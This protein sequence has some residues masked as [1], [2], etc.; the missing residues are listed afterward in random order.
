MARN[1]IYDDSYEDPEDKNERQVRERRFF[2][3]S[4]AA[5]TVADQIERIYIN[6][7]SFKSALASIDRIFQL[8]SRTTV[9]QGMMLIGEPGTGKSCVMKLFQAYAPRDALFSPSASTIL[10]RLQ[11]KP[12]VGRI[13]THILRQL[14][15]PFSNV[16]RHAVGL[17]RDIA[18]EAIKQKRHRLLMVDE[19]HHLV[20]ARHANKDWHEGNE[21]SEFLREVMDECQLG[22]VLAAT[23]TL[24]QLADIDRHLCSRVSARIELKDFS[25]GPE[26]IAFLQAYV[27]Q[28][29]A[30]DLKGI[31]NPRSA[32]MWLAASNGNLRVFKQL[33]VEGV[34]IAVDDGKRSIELPHLKTAFERVFGT[35]TRRQNPFIEKG[36]K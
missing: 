34:L 2:M 5:L 11:E 20:H 14:D 29:K 31:E 28:C 16:P 4:P 36:E 15:Y 8:G 24:D 33:L 13:L 22:L 1:F 21:V 9:P 35:D 10:I 12:S 30:F 6:H 27:Q 3:Y 23:H 18:I 7:H 32:S 19:A 25:K 26:W 17:K